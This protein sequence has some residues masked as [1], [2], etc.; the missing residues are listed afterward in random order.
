MSYTSMIL[1]NMQVDRGNEI[2]KELQEFHDK[3]Y[4]FH[5]G[6][7]LGSMCSQ[8]HPIAKKAYEIFLETNIGDPGLFKG[9]REIENSHA[10]AK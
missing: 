2:L 8:P 3:D 9:T 5:S 6:H 1:E 4:H 10:Q 7:I